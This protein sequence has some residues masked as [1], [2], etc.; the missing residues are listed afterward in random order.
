MLIHQDIC[1]IYE[2]SK[3]L[4]CVKNLTLFLTELCWSLRH[5]VPVLSTWG[6]WHLEGFI[7]AS[8]YNF[9]YI[10][11]NHD[12]NN[13]NND[14]N[15]NKCSST[16]NFHHLHNFYFPVLIFLCQISFLTTAWST[17]GH[18]FRRRYQIGSI[19]WMLSKWVFYRTEHRANGG[20]L[21]LNFEGPGIQRW[22]K[23]T[24]RDQKVDKKNV[25]I[26]LVIMFTSRVIVI[27]MSNNGS[28]LYFL[29]I[30][31]KN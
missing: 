1:D 11:N 6:E 9:K 14:T 26:C 20:H 19:T 4:A 21:K 16:T 8:F 2:I 30:T 31:A 24:D 29:L 12:K 23:P 28:F 22:N 15:N 10:A 3:I 7:A 17:L 18:Y 13:S 5:K 27:K 25:F